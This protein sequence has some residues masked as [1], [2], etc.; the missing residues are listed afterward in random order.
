MERIGSHS[1]SSLIAWI[2][3]AGYLAEHGAK[4]VTLFGAYDRKLIQPHTESADLERRTSHLARV[5]SGPL[6][7]SILDSMQHAIAQKPVS[8]AI[9]KPTESSLILVGHD[10]NLTN[11]AG[12]LDLSWLIDRRR[13]RGKTNEVDCGR[14]RLFVEAPVRPLVHIRIGAKSASVSG[15]FNLREIAKL[16]DCLK[17]SPSECFTRVRALVAQGSEPGSRVFWSNVTLRHS[18][19][20]KADHELADGS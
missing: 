14:Q 1:P 13:D 18:E 17:Q 15:D 2:A 11:V 5:Q 12:A 19:H 6:L 7:K 16:G 10:T 9:G 8:G 20:F 4:L 3:P